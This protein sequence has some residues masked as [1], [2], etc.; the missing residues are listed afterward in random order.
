[1]KIKLIQELLGFPSITYFHDSYLSQILIVVDKGFLWRILFIFK[2][3][4]V[5]TRPNVRKVI[6]FSGFIQ[7]CH[8]IFWR[9]SVIETPFLFNNFLFLKILC[10][11]MYLTNLSIIDLSFFF[12]LGFPIR[13]DQSKSFGVISILCI[14]IIWLPVYDVIHFEITLSFLTILFSCMT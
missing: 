1:M 14:V 4:F 8:M 5:C 10:L 13:C 2:K 7:F 6:S 3:Y 11:K 9:L 12:V